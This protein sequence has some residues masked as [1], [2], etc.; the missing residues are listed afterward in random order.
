MNE[1][2][3]K[4]RTHSKALRA[5]RPVPAYVYRL[6]KSLAAAQLLAESNVVF[7]ISRSLIPPSPLTI[8]WCTTVAHAA[9]PS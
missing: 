8:D 6:N 2:A 3:T 4:K 9:V 1:N 5:P 7:A